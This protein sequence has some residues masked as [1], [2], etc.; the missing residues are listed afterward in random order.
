[1]T[2]SS[3]CGALAAAPPERLTVKRWLEEWL[4]DVVKADP[5]INPRTHYDYASISQLHLI[6]E[7]GHIKLAR[8]SALDVERMVRRK[9]KSGLSPRRVQY[10]HAVLRASLS[11]AVRSNVLAVN[12]A[13]AAKVSNGRKAEIEPITPGEART[14]LTHA[15]DTREEA[16][17]VLALTLGLRQGELLGMQWSAVDLE[18][19]ILHVRRTAQ[20]FGGQRHEGPPKTKKSARTLVMPHI[21]RTALSRWAARQAGRVN[22]ASQVPSARCLRLP[23]LFALRFVI[24]RLL[25]RYVEIDFS[26]PDV[27]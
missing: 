6:P 25:C 19:D 22:R 8:L 5:D 27:N 12:V 10:I 9:R 15:R 24:L 3:N 17:Y 21:A 2:R 13:R 11:H 16:I 7:I 18:H 20:Y 14:F 23:S 26:K 4:E 1:M